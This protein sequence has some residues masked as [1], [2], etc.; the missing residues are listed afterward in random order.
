MNEYLKNLNKIEFVVTF[1]CSGRCKHCS[2]GDHTDS[3]KSID[4]EVAVN[5]IKRVAGEYD[6]KTIMAFGGEPLLYPDVTCKIMQAASEMNVPKRQI[7]TNG[8][9]SK[10]ADRI[11]E[12]VKKLEL[13]G[14]NEIL[15]SV[16]AFHQQTIPLDI[17]KIFAKE[18]K[19][20]DI[21]LYLQPAWLVSPTHKN[22]Y[23]VQTRKILDSF[24]DISENDGNIIFPEGNAKKYLAEYFT[25]DTP[26]NPYIDDPQDV[27]CLSFSPDGS[28]LD[29]NAC[30]KDIMDI[31]KDYV[32]L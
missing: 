24:C 5:A 16:D 20:T 8:F 29:S 13:S 4:T 2:E 30:Q 32:P 12:V 14:T 3:G 31:I 26:I 10:D 1:A 18:V 6:V 7:I 27:R 21:S 15:L 22:P 11:R 19:K 25:D 23:N 28:V 9:F 17:V